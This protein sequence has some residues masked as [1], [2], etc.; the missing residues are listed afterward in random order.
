MTSPG[1]IGAFDRVLVSDASGFFDHAPDVGYRLLTSRTA[2]TTDIL[3]QREAELEAETWTRE[4]GERLVL[5]R[6]SDVVDDLPLLDTWFRAQ[7][8][9]AQ[10]LLKNVRTDFDPFPHDLTRALV[11]HGY[12]VAFLRAFASALSCPLDAYVAAA[13]RRL[14]AT[15]EGGLR[16]WDPMPPGWPDRAAMSHEAT[17]AAIREHLVKL[18]EAL[19]A[20]DRVL[21]REPEPA[22][23]DI[24]DQL[25][26]EERDQLK[27]LETLLL[28]SSAR[29]V[30][31]WNPRDWTSWMLL[32]LVTS[33]LVLGAVAVLS[34]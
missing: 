12:E 27:Q 14:P 6:I 31:L 25:A 20:A 19:A 18:Y 33:M 1:A 32:A 11:R 23:S 4:L 30:G 24:R 10:R 3:M 2:R 15:L 28:N 5:F 26:A 7:S 16:P 17:S 29:P 8:P 34:T 9:K 21:H 13:A 22:R